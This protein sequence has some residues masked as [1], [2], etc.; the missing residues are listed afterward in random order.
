MEEKRKE[1]TNNCIDYV[2]IREQPAGGSSI[3]TDAFF[4]LVTTTGSSGKK[5]RLQ[6]RSTSKYCIILLV[7]R[8]QDYQRMCKPYLGLTKNSK[9]KAGLQQNL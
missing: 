1:K 6:R 3:A 4:S 9:Q 7:N 8:S 5:H 2:L